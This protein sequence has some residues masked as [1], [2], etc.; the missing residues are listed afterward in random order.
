MKKIYSLVQPELTLLEQ[1]IEESLVSGIPYV[2]R[3]VN[4][5]TKGKGK[6]L[7]PL[8][9]FLSGKLCGSIKQEHIDVATSLELLH[10]ATLLHDDVVDQSRVRRNN[11]THNARFGNES[12]V[13]FGDYML[14]CALCTASSDALFSCRGIIADAVKKV[15]EGEMMQISNRYNADLTE[16]EYC[17]IIDKKT[18][19]L[20]AAA[21]HVGALLSGAS[22]TA[23]NSLREYGKNVGL[24]FQIMD[25]LLDVFGDQKSAGKPLDLDLKRGDITLPF[26]QLVCKTG[27]NEQVKELIFSHD[28]TGSSAKLK[29]LLHE[30]MCL[31]SSLAAAK[32]YAQCAKKAIEN[33]SSE[34]DI[35][36]LTCL[37]DYVVDEK[38]ISLL[39]AAVC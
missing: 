9:V 38:R 2:D 17:E 21:C 31:D 23:Q 34:T 28:D 15:C 37:A 22:E 12:A 20:F 6:R 30:N 16:R 14:S 7:R 10:T 13:M 4:H 3:C 19:S 35:S 36:H 11:P 1:K 29:E 32:R 39:E 5:A 26:I 8:F 18:A 24:A 33:M 25:D 27:D